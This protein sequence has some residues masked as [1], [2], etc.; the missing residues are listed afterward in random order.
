MLTSICVSSR[1]LKINQ[2]IIYASTI[3]NQAKVTD[4]SNMFRQS[5]LYQGGES[6]F[7]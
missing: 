7:S 3:Y 1:T 4:K 2:P 6:A 5:G